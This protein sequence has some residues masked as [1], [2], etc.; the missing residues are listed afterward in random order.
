MATYEATIRSSSDPS[1]FRRRAVSPNDGIKGLFDISAL[2]LTRSNFS[3]RHF[4]IV[5][6]WPRFFQN[7]VHCNFPGTAA[8]S[9]LLLCQRSRSNSFI[10]REGGAD[11]THHGRLARQSGALSQP[12]DRFYAGTMCAQK[13][14]DFELLKFVACP[15]QLLV[16]GWE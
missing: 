15:V 5:S 8:D 1:N 9:L 7:R 3:E 4:A 2:T 16:A 11:G 10:K 12:I 6:E 14:R 13:V